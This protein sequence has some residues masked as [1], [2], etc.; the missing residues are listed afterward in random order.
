MSYDPGQPQQ[1]GYRQA[2]SF[3]P[4]F[5]PPPAQKPPHNIAMPRSRRILS[6]P[7]K[8]SRRWPWIIGGLVCILIIAAILTTYYLS[9]LAGPTV[10]VENYYKAV[11][12]QNYTL[13]YSYLANN[14]TLTSQ[15][16]KIPIGAQQDYATSA[17][18]LDSN[19][20][21]VISYTVATT[22]NSTLLMINTT[23]SKNAHSIHYSVRFT[24]IQEAG[25]WKIKDM[26]GG[27]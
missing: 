16:Q 4:A 27:F 23:R 20:G 7:S 24:M 25:T 26:N 11:S 8:T 3:S 5:L 21:S 22:S 2:E 13:A 9:T 17:R 14:A 1:P 15:N 6:R 18:L 19:I 10:T 12:Q